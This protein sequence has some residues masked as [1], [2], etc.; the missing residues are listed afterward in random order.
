MFDVNL[1]DAGFLAAAL[2]ALAAGV[3][4]FLSPCV[5]PI[6]PPY[7]AYMGGISMS[8]LRGDGGERRSALLPALFFVLAQRR[9]SA[10]E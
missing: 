4:S 10:A 5:L 8:E 6:V 3:L 7:L 2:V 9:L 1:L